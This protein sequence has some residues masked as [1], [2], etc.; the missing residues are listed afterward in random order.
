MLVIITDDGELIDMYPLKN[1]PQQ[2]IIVSHTY[3]QYYLT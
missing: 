2:I 1:T 3:V